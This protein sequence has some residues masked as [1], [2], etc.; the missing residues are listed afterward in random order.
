M[1][2]I[3]VCY[4]YHQV[5]LEGLSGEKN[6]QK[7]LKW[8]KITQ[9]LTVFCSLTAFQAS[10]MGLW[11]LVVIVGPKVITRTLVGVVGAI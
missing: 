5:A 6:H 2:N 3:L 9:F 7:S 1:P 11:R 4:T 8:Q 10:D